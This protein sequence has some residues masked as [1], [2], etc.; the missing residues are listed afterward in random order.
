MTYELPHADTFLLCDIPRRMTAHIYSYFLRYDII[1]REISHLAYIF[2][3]CDVTNDVTYFLI[4]S[5]V[6]H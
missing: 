3:Q 4:T 1:R 6:I 5:D 2:L